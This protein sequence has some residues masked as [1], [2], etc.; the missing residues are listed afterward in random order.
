MLWYSRVL[1]APFLWLGC[2]NP[3]PS[4]V[5]TGAADPLAGV[6]GAVFERIMEMGPLGPQPVDPT[7]RWAD[8]DDAAALGQYLYFDTRLS[9]DGNV[10]CASCH[11]PSHGGADTGPTSDGAGTG[12]MNAPTT[13][14]GGYQRWFFW[15][16]RADSLW[17]Q[18]LGPLESAREHGSS[19]TDIARAVYDDPKLRLM[20]EVLFGAL[21]D[22][23][24]TRRFPRGAMPSLEDSDASKA[25]ASMNPADQQAVTE[26]FVSVGKALD[27][28][29]RKLT[30]G[31]T[32]LDGFLEDYKSGTQPQQ[33]LLTESEVRGMVLFA[34]HAQCHFCHSGALFS[35][36]EFHNIG[37]AS[38]TLDYGRF[39]GITE[40]AQSEFNGASPWSDDPA[41]GAARIVPLV[42]SDEQ[43]GQ[44]RTPSLRNVSQTAPY[45]HDGSRAT[46][47]EVIGHYNEVNEVPPFGHR[48]EI[49]EPLYLSVQDQADLVAFLLTLEAP[50]P[51]ES[52][53]QSPW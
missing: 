29:Q 46:L 10:A 7:N 30:L 25:W 1:W 14:N 44:F 4:L 17:A 21:P 19:R 36:R 5:D 23:S 15:N 49:L 3:P 28:Y 18:A 39:Q 16:G 13:W 31:P 2:G 22:L 8:D 27:A 52:W 51:P 24:D 32:R 6:Q 34:D 42:Q 26:V 12:V 11:S 9:S 50:P 47:S 37:L 40:L 20:Y 33:P 53:T 35:N 45:M 48:E 38:E 41:Y 43:L